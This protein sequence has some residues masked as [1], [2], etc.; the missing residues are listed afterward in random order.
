[1]SARVDRAE[2]LSQPEGRRRSFL[3]FKC[4][5]AVE[6]AGRKDSPTHPVGKER[7]ES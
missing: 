1:M 7:G 4:L 6:N 5:L 2:E 3:L